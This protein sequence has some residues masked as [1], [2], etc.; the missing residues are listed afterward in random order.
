M[1]TTLKRLHVSISNE[2][3]DELCAAIRSGLAKNSTLEELA[4]NDIVPSGSDGAV[5]ARN[6]LTFLRTNSTLKSLAVSFV[7]AQ[8]ESYVSAFRLEAVKVMENTFLESLTIHSTGS[9]KFEELFAL[10]SALQLNTTPKTLGHKVFLG[11]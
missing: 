11:L 4:L 9:G 6:A 2:F 3:G 8:T 1:N 5:L 7:R 10:I